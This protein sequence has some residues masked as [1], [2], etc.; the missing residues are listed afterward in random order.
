MNSKKINYYLIAT[1][2]ILTLTSLLASFFLLDEILE[3]SISVGVNQKT[4]G[5]LNDYQDDLKRLRELDPFNEKQYHQRFNK[6]QNALFVYQEPEKFVQLIKQSYLYYYLI[7]F[8]GLIVLSLII[9]YFLAR[10][11][12][13]SYKI[14][15]LRDIAKSER[16]IELENFKSW[17]RIVSSLAHEVRNPLTPIEVMVSS[18]SE[19]QQRESSSEFSNRLKTT[20]KVVQEEVNRLKG[21]IEHFSRFSKFPEPVLEATD[22]IDYLKDFKNKHSTNKTRIN[23]QYLLPSSSSISAKIDPLLFKQCLLNLIQNAKDANTDRKLIEI[24]ISFKPREV[25]P[26]EIIVSNLGQEIEQSE[27]SKIF[28]FGY[29]TK[30][31]KLNHGIGLFIVKNI[32]IK[33]N[34]S[35]SNI[36]F[37]NGSAF[38][39]IIPMKTISHE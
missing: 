31:T 39:I 19:A 1:I 11:I 2:T 9:T 13:N 16:L 37:N 30:S 5:I 25:L 6:V 36:P 14:L 3:S 22:L 12:S 34:A 32:L 7:L 28:Q 8:I 18:L 24:N 29:S 35:I 21:M 15:F 33:H 27:R 26:T 17:Q 10:K 4:T 20:Q 38:S 23:L